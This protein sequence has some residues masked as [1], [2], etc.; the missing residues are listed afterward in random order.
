MLVH[1]GNI[2]RARPFAW[3]GAFKLTRMKVLIVA[4][5]AMASTACGPMSSASA[6]VEPLQEEA[7][8]R[9][10]YGGG[11]GPGR[12]GR[13]GHPGKP[14]GDGANAD[15]LV[16]SENAYGVAATVSLTTP[17]KD[18]RNN[19][20]FQ[21]LGTNG[22]TCESCHV[23]SANWGLAPDEVQARFD[24]TD[25]EDPV[26][27]LVDGANSPKADVST[28]EA[29]RS[30]YSMLLSKAVIRI[31]LPLPPSGEVELVSV[32]DP[33]GFASA[34]E[35]SMFRRPLPST[36]LAFLTATMWDG[37]ESTPVAD[38]L[39]GPNNTQQ[40]LAHQANDATLGHAEATT[41]L[42]AEAQKQVVDFEL[43]LFSAQVADKAAGSL[44][45]R[46]AQGGPVALSKQAFYFGQN[47][48]VAGD[49]RTGAPFDPNVFT[50]YD[51]WSN[52]A[53]K[54]QA[55]ARAS[56][57]RGEALFNRTTFTIA[58]VRGLNDVLGVPALQGTCTTCHDSP[59]I[60]HH[61][62]RLPLDIG[63]TTAERR[64][65]DMPLYTFCKRR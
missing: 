14:N 49:S 22:R 46:G 7:D 42:S 55:R 56:V 32:D 27:R 37:R 15:G 17:L 19:P 21:S 50:L 45:E 29:R 33:Y 36:N 39:R 5:H 3:R 44:T 4:A 54:R 20:F 11:R 34:K 63:L 12:P 64:T 9:G 1:T 60:G 61:S 52:G 28:V 65:P 53:D 30:A 38:A 41:G 35:L 31:G 62:V 16:L 57:Q 58:G 23:L 47:D 10:G 59:N 18:A 43:G 25:G 13:P 51:T 48:V 24:A 6:D 26:F 8:L 40:D 2:T